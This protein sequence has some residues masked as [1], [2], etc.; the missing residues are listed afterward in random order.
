MIQLAWFHTCHLNY[1]ERNKKSCPVCKDPFL[2]RVN[3]HDTS[4][5]IADSN[6]SYE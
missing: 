6:N 1:L 4:S 5:N 2:T 3:E